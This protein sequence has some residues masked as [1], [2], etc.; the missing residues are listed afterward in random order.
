LLIFYATN[1]VSL[2]IMDEKKAFF[3]ES[4]FC[5]ATSRIQTSSIVL[6]VER[7]GFLVV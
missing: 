5:A 3:S 7:G 1:L 6:V 4:F 2:K